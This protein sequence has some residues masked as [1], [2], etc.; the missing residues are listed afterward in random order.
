MDAW[1]KLAKLFEDNKSAIHFCVLTLMTAGGQQLF[2]LV[3]FQCPCSEQNFIYGFVFLFAPAI[4]LMIIGF[5]INTRTWKFFTGCCL[6]PVKMCPRGYRCQGLCVLGQLTMNALIVPLMWISLALLHGT[7][8]TCAMSGWLDPDH[9][10]HLCKSKSRQC[11]NHLYKVPCGKASMSTNET[12][13]IVLELQAQS[14]VI[15]WCLIIVLALLS[16]LWNCWTSCRSNVSSVQMQFWKIYISK[17]KDKFDELAQEY[18]TK[19]AERNLK[20]FFENRDPENFEL[21]CNKAWEQVSALY[22]FNPKHQFYSMLHRF[23]E[24]GEKGNGR[25][26]SLDFVDSKA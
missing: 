8:Y 18:A 14:Q 21:P 25:E 9:V 4:V 19:L 6:N 20:S 17:E 26:F 22:T 15:G 2:S 10:Q 12:Q 5:F 3:A 23:V 24:H 11:H 13:E 1:K 7:Y 16:L